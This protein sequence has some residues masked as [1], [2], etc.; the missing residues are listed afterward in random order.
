MGVLEFELCDHGLV[1]LGS[2]EQGLVGVLQLD[3]LGLELLVEFD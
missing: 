2:S 3:D 1:V